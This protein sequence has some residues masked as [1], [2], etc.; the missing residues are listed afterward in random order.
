GHRA[1]RAAG[2]GFKTMIGAVSSRLAETERIDKE[3]FRLR[4]FTDGEHSAVESLD[5]YVFA[6]FGR[7]PWLARIVLVFD[8]FERQS[9]GM[10][11]LDELLSEPFLGFGLVNLVPLELVFPERKRSGGYCER[12]GV[13]LAGSPPSQ[14][15]PVRECRHDRSRLQILIRV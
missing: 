5:G 4:S 11:E 14:L 7:G 9:G 6:D 10:S 12:C 2:P 13:Y 3:A 1:I 15:L 8:D